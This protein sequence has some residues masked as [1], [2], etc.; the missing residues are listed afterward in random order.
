MFTIFKEPR[1]IFR[2]RPPPFFGL[3]ALG[4]VAGLYSIFLLS[5]GKANLGTDFGG[6]VLLHLSAKKDVPFDSLRQ[7]FDHVGLEGRPDPSHQMN[8]ADPGSRPWC[9]SAVRWKA[10]SARR[11][12]RWWMPFKKPNRMRVS[13]GRQ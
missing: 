6:G 5:Q 13:L 4:M 12:P 8:N 10:V 11:R 3:S 1:L 9:V 7:V 2:V